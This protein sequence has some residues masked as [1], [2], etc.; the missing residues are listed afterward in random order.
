MI[1]QITYDDQLFRLTG[2]IHDLA[3]KV[4]QHILSDKRENIALKICIYKQINQEIQQHIRMVSST[5]SK[6]KLKHI[7]N[8]YQENMDRQLTLYQKT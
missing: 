7:Y 4:E 5:S 3:G 6:L 2:N 8:K 1:I